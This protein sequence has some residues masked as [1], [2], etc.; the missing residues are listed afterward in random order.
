MS[1]HKAVR[2]HAPNTALDLS[3]VPNAAYLMQVTVSVVERLV[4]LILYTQIAA[5]AA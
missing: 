5:S 2:K 1:N 4:G 3:A